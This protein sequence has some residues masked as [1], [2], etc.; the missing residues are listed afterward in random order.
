MRLDNERSW[1]EH[2]GKPVAGQ[3]ADA[4]DAIAELED[5]GR[6]SEAQ[7][8]YLERRAD[9]MHPGPIGQNLT[10]RMLQRAIE[11]PTNVGVNESWARHTCPCGDTGLVET[12]RQGDRVGAYRPC[13]RCNPKGYAIWRDCH[14]TGCRGCERCKPGGR[15]RGL[16]GDHYAERAE[17]RQADDQAR[18]RGDLL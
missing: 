12:N 5:E 6:I 7:V 8:R 17:T 16:Q 18:L 1:A 3:L 4:W 15:R 10:L 11:H 13:D 14:L 9:E 2:R